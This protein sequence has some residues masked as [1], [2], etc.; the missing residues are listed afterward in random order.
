MDLTMSMYA[1]SEDYWK[2][3]AEAAE[4]ALADLGVTPEEARAGAARSKANQR[5]AERYRWLREQGDGRCTEKDGYGGQ[6]L[7]MGDCLDAAVDAAMTLHNPTAKRRPLVDVRLSARLGQMQ[8]TGTDQ[9]T[10][11]PARVGALKPSRPKACG[12]QR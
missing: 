6:T 11:R 3:R 12:E 8:S 7:K 5:D 1:T 10:S 4:R 9:H 2:A